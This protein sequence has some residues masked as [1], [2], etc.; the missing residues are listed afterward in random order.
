MYDA[1]WIRL[2]WCDGAN[3]T[4]ARVAEASSDW[5]PRI[6]WP[7]ALQWVRPNSALANVGMVL[8]DLML[9]F[10][11]VCM[12]QN[13]TACHRMPQNATECHRM[14]RCS[15]TPEAGDLFIAGR[16]LA[17]GGRSAIY[18]QANKVHWAESVVKIVLEQSQ[19]I[20]SLWYC[21]ILA[22]GNSVFAVPV[23]WNILKWLRFL[24]R[25]LRPLS[26]GIRCPRNDSGARCINCRLRWP[27]LNWLTD[28]LGHAHIAIKHSRTAGD[29]SWLPTMLEQKP[30]FVAEFCTFE[31]TRCPLKTKRF[32][33]ACEAKGMQRAHAMFGKFMFDGQACDSGLG[34]VCLLCQSQWARPRQKPSYFLLLCYRALVAAFMVLWETR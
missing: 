7:R 25:K 15:W 13:D 26:R 17:A 14:S 3:I 18:K 21:A 5:P 19:P 34:P 24:S 20:K 2:M 28:P 11:G 6:S 10:F 32:Q 22:P 31:V 8:L 33:D 9:E 27:D 29:G 4:C 30:R 1:D 16:V 12:T 23:D